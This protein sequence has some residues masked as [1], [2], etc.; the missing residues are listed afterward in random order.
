MCLIEAKNL[1]FVEL[2]FWIINCNAA[3]LKSIQADWDIGVSSFSTWAKAGVSIDL[4]LLPQVSKAGI[5]TRY[6]AIQV[7]SVY[8]PIHILRVVWYLI[9]YS[10]QYSIPGKWCYIGLT[11]VHTKMIAKE[12]FNW[13]VPHFLGNDHWKWG[14]NLTQTMDWGIHWHSNKYTNMVSWN[15][16]IWGHI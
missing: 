10:Y 8:S 14:H 3:D 4:H 9:P 15:S 13:M 12:C 7:R 16:H 5:E 6:C 1:E 11:L 2:K